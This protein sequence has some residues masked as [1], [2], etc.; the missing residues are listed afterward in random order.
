MIIAQA[1]VA[2]YHNQHFEDHF[3]LLIV[4]TF[5]CLHEEANDFFHQCQCAMVGKRF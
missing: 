1:K 3:I 5:K 2:L 4:K